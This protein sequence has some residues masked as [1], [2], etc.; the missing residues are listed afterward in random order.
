[1]NSASAALKKTYS[2]RSTTGFDGGPCD[3]AGTGRLADSAAVTVA[4]LIGTSAPTDFT[5]SRLDLSMARSAS[6]FVSEAYGAWPRRGLDG[7]AAIWLSVRRD[8][9]RLE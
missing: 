8:R 9:V 1:M 5:N 2:G 4:R 7:R 3:V 6:S